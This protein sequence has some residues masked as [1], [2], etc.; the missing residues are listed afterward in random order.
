MKYMYESFYLGILTIYDGMMTWDDGDQI[1]EGIRNTNQVC[2]EKFERA[3]SRCNSTLLVR[4]VQHAVKL[5][6]TRL[7]LAIAPL[8]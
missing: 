2:K 7:P 5:D 4:K 8:T 3:N 1:L 6:Q